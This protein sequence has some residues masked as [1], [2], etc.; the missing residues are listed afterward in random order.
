MMGARLPANHALVFVAVSVLKRGSF[1]SSSMSGHVKVVGT[2]SRNILASRCCSAGSAT[3]RVTAVFKNSLPA[4]K[5]GT[6]TASSGSQFASLS[7]IEI[8][9]GACHLKPAPEVAPTS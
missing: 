3:I 4:L 7:L 9:G 2:K 5:T 8:I 6:D 1:E